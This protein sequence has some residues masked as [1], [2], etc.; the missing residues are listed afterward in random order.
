[1]AEPV[2]VDGVP[3]KITVE[4]FRRYYLMSFPKLAG[5]QYDQL[6]SDSIDTVYGIFT[7]VGTLWDMQPEQVWYDK[8]VTCYRLLTA[9][10]IADVNPAFVTGV[11][12]MGG[13]PLKRK[14][15]DGVD[16]TFADGD[17]GNGNK[18]YQDLLA[19]LKSNPW[20]AKAYLMIRAA[21]KRVLIRN[22]TV[23]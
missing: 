5:E 2:F 20:G 1:M 21:A 8:T 12:N 6:I 22:R 3:A 18:D 13:I 14:K 10:Y 9:W 11:P 19:S 16:L 23:I 15:V 4:D 17:V 7:G